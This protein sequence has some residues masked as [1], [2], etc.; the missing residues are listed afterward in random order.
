MSYCYQG[1]CRIIGS[2]ASSPPA[3]GFISNARQLSRSLISA[4]L[5]LGKQIEGAGVWRALSCSGASIGGRTVGGDVVGEVAA[6]PASSS[7]GSVSVSSSAGLC[8][9]RLAGDGVEVFTVGAFQFSIALGGF[10]GRCS[11]GGS[12]GC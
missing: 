7:T 6:Q 10:G 1:E 8:L 5:Q 9:A 12:F 11:C 2:L 3:A 4:A